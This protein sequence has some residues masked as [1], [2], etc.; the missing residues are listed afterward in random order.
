MERFQEDLTT[1][2]D[3]MKSHYDKQADL[4]NSPFSNLDR[5]IVGCDNSILRKSN[6]GNQVSEI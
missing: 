2:L 4:R 1:P 3:S 6:E 5:K